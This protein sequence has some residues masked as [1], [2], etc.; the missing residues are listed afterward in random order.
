MHDKTLQ[1]RF[2]CQGTIDHTAYISAGAAINF[3]NKVGGMVS[4]K[5]SQFQLQ[6]LS[7]KGFRD[8][9]LLPMCDAKKKKKK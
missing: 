5:G 8:T 1:D 2:Y 3:Y 4:D 6:S 7:I 9:F